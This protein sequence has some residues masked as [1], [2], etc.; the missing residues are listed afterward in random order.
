MRSAKPLT[1]SCSVP[2]TPALSSGSSSPPDSPLLDLLA[3]MVQGGEFDSS[4]DEDLSGTMSTMSLGC[5]STTHGLV[6]TRA[7]KGE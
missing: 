4:A 6:L 2:S 1:D 7:A 3:R 5:A